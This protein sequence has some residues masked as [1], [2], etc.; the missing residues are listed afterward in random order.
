[1]Q[2]LSR[3]RA[4]KAAGIATA[5]AAAVDAA[6]REGGPGGNGGDPANAPQPEVGE[7]P[8]FLTAGGTTSTAE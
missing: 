5:T 4:A 3:A 7:L 8:A 2:W 1:M 6:M